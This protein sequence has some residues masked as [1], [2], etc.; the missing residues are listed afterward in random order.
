M[1]K[2]FAVLLALVLVLAFAAC[3]PKPETPPAEGGET[4]APESG[5]LK[6]VN[7]V[8][9]N[10]GDKSFFDS[11][12][13]G[14]KALA[15][16]GVIEYRTIEMG[17]DEAT[18]QNY[19][20]EVTDSGEYDIVVCGTWQMPAYLLP[21][22][23]ANPDQQYIIY[24]TEVVNAA[25]EYLPNIA[26]IQYNQNDMGYLVGVFAGLMELSELEGLNDE[27]ILGFVGGMDSP[28]ICDF[29]VGYIEGAQSVNPDVKVDWRWINS[30]T[31]T[32][33]GKEIGAAEIQAGAD[34][35]WGCGGDAGSA[36]VEAC[37][38]AGVWFI[39]VDSDQELT[40]AEEYAA[41]T[42]TSGLKNVGNSLEY[43]IK[44][45]VAGNKQYWGTCTWLGL[46]E[47]GVG[48]VTDKNFAALAT[49]EIQD[50]VLGVQDKILSGE[51][52][53]DSAFDAD[54]DYYALMDSVKAGA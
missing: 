30:Y 43:V 9:G 8:N 47:G 23:E 15:D 11:A 52:K 51:V 40:L 3:T 14:L 53:V 54:F 12:E 36:A 50:T 46:A 6:V 24:D 4:E 16:E 19:V 25:G 10:L 38:E 32:A 31:D 22:A 41:I 28:V 21:V 7:L 44:E 33:L 42:L 48:I 26:N 27:N 17:P 20:Q 2:L 18:W 49:Q 1:K 37:K 34:I 45:Y 5:A 39:G 13:S 35:I 29:L